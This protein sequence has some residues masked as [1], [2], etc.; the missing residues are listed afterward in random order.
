MEDWA[1][2][3]WAADDAGGFPA[4]SACVPPDVDAIHVE[5]PWLFAFAR[6]LRERSRR[7]LHVIYGS[8]NADRIYGGT[9]ND[10]ISG[11]GGNDTIYGEDG[12][13]RLF[14]GDG[15]DYIHV[16]TGTNL[17]RGGSSIDRIFARTAFDDLKQNR[18]DTITNLGL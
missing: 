4:L 18:E 7:R 16:G 10:W 11:F 12:D 14:G 1:L 6:R 5:Q 17:V 8:A 9:G 3:R 2:G 13:D 15:K